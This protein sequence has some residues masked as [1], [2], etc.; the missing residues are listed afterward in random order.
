MLRCPKLRRQTHRRP[1]SDF[2]HYHLNGRFWL[3]DGSVGLSHA[4]VPHNEWADHA[5]PWAAAQNESLNRCRTQ[6]ASVWLSSKKAPI[7]CGVALVIVTPSAGKSKDRTSSIEESLELRFSSAFCSFDLRL[8]LGVA[9]ILC[10]SA[11][12]IRS[13]FSE[14]ME[15]STAYDHRRPLLEGNLVRK[16]SGRCHC[17][18]SLY[19]PSTTS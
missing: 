17:F 15:C 19:P 6:S 7:V 2:R 8:Q 1:D 14:T 18:L 9:W 16:G 5:R 10:S 11:P 3:V 4:H 12:T 13:S